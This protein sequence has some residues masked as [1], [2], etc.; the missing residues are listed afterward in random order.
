MTDRTWALVQTLQTTAPKLC[1]NRIEELTLHPLE[2]LQGK[3]VASTERIN[4]YLLQLIQE[5]RSSGLNWLHEASER[6]RY[7]NSHNCWQRSK[8]V[9]WLFSYSEN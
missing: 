3:E 6:Q 9:W 5:W 7:P 2:C 8:G 4:L 1:I